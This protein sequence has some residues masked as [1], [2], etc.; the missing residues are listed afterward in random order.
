VGQRYSIETN[1]QVKK[2]LKNR[3]E[4][5]NENLEIGSWSLELRILHTMLSN[6]GQAFLFTRINSLR[7]NLNLQLMNESKK[8]YLEMWSSEHFEDSLLLLKSLL[9]DGIGLMKIT[10]PMSKYNEIT[11]Y[12]HLI[13]QMVFRRSASIHQ[14]FS[15]DS[16]YGK[17]VTDVSSVA[18]ISRA[19][20]ESSLLAASFGLKKEKSELESLR[21]LL[22]KL[23]EIKNRLQASSIPL[24]VEKEFSNLIAQEKSKIENLGIYDTNKIEINRCIKEK[25]YLI[26]EAGQTL[27]AKNWK[28]YESDHLKG[29]MHLLTNYSHPNKIG[30]DYFASTYLNYNPDN[31]TVFVKNSIVFLGYVYYVVMSVNNTFPYNECSVFCADLTK[32]GKCFSF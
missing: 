1:R 29:A 12:Q 5:K 18:V 26:A 31:H 10:A 25:N 24:D 9:D 6:R 7:K 20:Y 22:W 11:K 4:N 23:A 21:F 27:K 30:V 3:N 2:I 14:L 8:N 15:K 13:F 16:F 17:Q 19:N 28:T 32:F